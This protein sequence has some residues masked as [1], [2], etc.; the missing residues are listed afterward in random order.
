MLLFYITKKMS[1][2]YWDNN[3]ILA[4][5][6]CLYSRIGITTHNKG[7]VRSAHVGNEMLKTRVKQ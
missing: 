3:Y 2:K 6:K 7:G 5:C 1:Q 4:H